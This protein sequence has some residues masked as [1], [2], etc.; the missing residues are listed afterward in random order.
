V[1]KIS[2]FQKN[3]FGVSVIVFTI[4]TCLAGIQLAE[5]QWD[6]ISLASVHLHGDILPEVTFDKTD[7]TF[8]HTQ[9]GVSLSIL[10]LNF[11]YMMDY[12]SWDKLGNLPFGN[13]KDEPWETLHSLSLS[14]MYGGEINEKWSWV[15]IAAGSAAFEKEIGSSYL[16]STLGGGAI[17]SLSDKWN[18][19]GGAG[20]MYTNAP[21]LD[22]GDLLDDPPEVIPVPVLG[23]QW[24]QD[25]ESGLSLS[26]IFPLEAS[27]S[28]RTF[29]GAL[30][31]SADFLAQS[32]DITYQFTPMFGVTLSGSL[33]NETIH[34]LADDNVAIPVGTKEGYLQNEGSTLDL[35]LNVKFSEHMNFKIGPYYMFNQEISIR[36]KEDKS[37]Q[38]LEA[39]DTFGGEFG[40]SFVF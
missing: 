5:A 8:L 22:F 40:L 3:L 13:G 37:L 28:Y 34:R 1:K 15:A 6:D 14:G 17:Y 23:A 30:S 32:A 4:I 12:Y 18:L 36:N 21:E 20:V 35:M 26:L 16:N 2:I 25:A 33:D 10:T 24:N 39:D 7:T 31:A 19:I 27:I 38:E 29:E 9:T 11:D